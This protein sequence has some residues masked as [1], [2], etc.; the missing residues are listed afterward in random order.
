MLKNRWNDS[1][2]YKK[3][4]ENGIDKDHKYRDRPRTIAVKQG[5][6]HRYMPDFENGDKGKVKILDISTGT[7]VFIELLN[8][9]GYETTGTEIPNCIYE[10]F[11]KSQK[12]NVIYHDS[13]E[14]PY[15]FKKNAFHLVTCIGAF[16][17]YPEEKRDEILKEIFRIAKKTVIISIEEVDDHN[18]FDVPEGWALTSHINTIYRWDRELK[19]KTR[20]EEGKEE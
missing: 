16:Q 3:A 17:H 15:P 20:E 14:I 9:M 4:D 11:H 8:D 7:G 10:P 13:T 6:I 12:L 5:F 18:P 19:E 1:R 2:I